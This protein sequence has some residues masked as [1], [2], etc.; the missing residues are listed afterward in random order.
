MEKRI[1]I[2][3]NGRKNERKRL[4]RIVDRSITVLCCQI[5]NSRLPFDGILRKE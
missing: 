2:Y 4:A 1:R 5:W 3:Q